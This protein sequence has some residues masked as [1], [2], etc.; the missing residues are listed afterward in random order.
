MATEFGGDE[1][2]GPGGPGNDTGDKTVTTAG[3]ER[4]GSYRWDY[5]YGRRRVRI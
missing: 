3:D 5:V 4:D 2:G 1:I